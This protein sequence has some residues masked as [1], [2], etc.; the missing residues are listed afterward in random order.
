MKFPKRIFAAVFPSLHLDAKGLPL[1]IQDIP[2]E[3]A[4]DILAA[5]IKRLLEEA[6]EHK[7]KAETLAQ[8]LEKKAA[9]IINPEQLR[10]AGEWLQERGVV[11][12]SGPALQALVRQLREIEAN[13]N[14]PPAVKAYV[15]LGYAILRVVAA[16]HGL[17]LASVDDILKG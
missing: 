17:A 15:E 12:L 9:A 13:P 16:Q 2:D 8:E 11:A 14:V 7:E 5:G 1:A 6:Q 3:R 4:R 10:E